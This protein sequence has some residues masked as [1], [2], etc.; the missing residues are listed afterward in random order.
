MMWVPP[1]AA[2]WGSTWG[3]ARVVAWGPTWGPPRAVVWGPTWG[4]PRAA[5]WGLLWEPMLMLPLLLLLRL[6]PLDLACRKSR[7]WPGT[8]IAPAL[9]VHGAL[10]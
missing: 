8:S 2:V 4:P 6:S 9:Q 7:T 3:P 1:R 5:V 10:V